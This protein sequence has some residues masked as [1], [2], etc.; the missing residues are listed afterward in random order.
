M[1]VVRGKERASARSDKQHAHT[2]ESLASKLYVMV[3]VCFQFLYLAKSLLYRKREIIRSYRTRRSSNE[4][5]CSIERAY[6]LTYL[7]T[8]FNLRNNN[9]SFLPRLSVESHRIII[10]EFSRNF[11][12]TNGRRNW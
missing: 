6:I 3:I 9:Q 4:P 5:G 7:S 8:I 1:R 10:I 12:P 11:P 2:R